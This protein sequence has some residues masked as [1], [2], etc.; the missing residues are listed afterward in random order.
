MMVVGI[1]DEGMGECLLVFCCIDEYDQGR[2][3]HY[4]DCDLSV[5]R[6]D[7]TSCSKHDIDS[8]YTRLE[9]CRHQPSR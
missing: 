9:Q 2:S 1:V 7:S 6:G 4:V 5:D 3:A 8:S